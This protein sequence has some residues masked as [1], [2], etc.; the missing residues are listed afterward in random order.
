MSGESPIPFPAIIVNSKVFSSTINGDGAKQ[1]KKGIKIKEKDH[2]NIGLYLL[3]NL[4]K[5]KK[6]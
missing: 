3:H 4:K 1:K 5:K 6:K 2:N